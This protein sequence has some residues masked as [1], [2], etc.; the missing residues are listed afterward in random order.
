[1]VA[2]EA[3]SFNTHNTFDR[4]L[5]PN[6]HL[7][8]LIASAKPISAVGRKLALHLPMDLLKTV[9]LWKH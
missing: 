9:T 4:Q 3:F 6:P 1:M 5:S 2:K 7:N 8:S